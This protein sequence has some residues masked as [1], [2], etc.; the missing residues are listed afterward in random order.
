MHI[1]L[2]H[3]APIDALVAWLDARPEPLW[4][5]GGAVRD[6]L[7]GRTALDLDLVV[8]GNAGRFAQ[9]LAAAVGGVAVPLDREQ[10]VYRIAIPGTPF[11]LDCAALRGETI[12]GDLRARDFTINAL[13]LP[14]SPAAFRAILAGS[15]PAGQ[16]IIDPLGGAA[17]LAARRLCLASAGAFQDDPLRILRGARI[18]TALD[19]AGDDALIAAAQARASDLQRVAPERIAAEMVA[20]IA[21]PHG[22]AAM[23]RLD[24]LG[25]LTICAPPLAAC[26]S[27]TQGKLHHWDVFEH[28]LEVIDSL[29][30]TVAL[31]ERG[32]AQPPD[33]AMIDPQTG[34]VAHPTALNLGGHNA[35]LLAYLREPLAESRTRL[36]LIK[37]AALFHDTGKPTTRQAD[38]EGR[39]RFPN[40]AEAGVPLTAAILEWWRLGRQARRFIEG[41]VQHH[42]R[43]GQLAAPQGPS[44]RALRHFFRDAGECALDVAFFS[45]ADHFAVY[46]PDPLTPFWMAHSS[47][48]SELVRRFYEEPEEVIPPHLIDGNDLLARFDLAPG[49]LVRVI[50]DQVHAA[51]LDGAIS[52]RAEALDLAARLISQHAE[53]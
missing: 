46:G 39:I 48:V 40:H 38:A 4:L 14:C 41:V 21:A 22:T 26:R 2:L 32:L 13:A 52:T 47:A 15:I 11:S 3:I 36:E 19:L 29:D 31:L 34:R 45:I 28:T 53:Q 17:D 30:H 12:Q 42:M 23:Q 50:L 20:M 24:A 6:A 9:G 35:D 44:A 49:P 18:A 33:P 25:A 37:V 27:V 16:E 43:P 1:P 7:A 8:A 5:V 51:R 10:G